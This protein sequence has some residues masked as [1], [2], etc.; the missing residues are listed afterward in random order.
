MPLRPWARLGNVTHCFIK[1]TCPLECCRCDRVN[2][3]DLSAES[4]RRNI[5]SLKRGNYFLSVS[6]SLVKIR[7]KIGHTISLLNVCA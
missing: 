5:N 2:C 6:L 4:S 7:V 1:F 3:S